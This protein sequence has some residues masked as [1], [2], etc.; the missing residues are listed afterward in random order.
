MAGIYKVAV[1]WTYKPDSVPL[2]IAPKTGVIMSL[3]LELPRISSD[4]PET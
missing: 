2:G 4:L 1:E 3:V